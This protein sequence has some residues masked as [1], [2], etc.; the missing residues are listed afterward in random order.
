MPP[1]FEPKPD[2][3]AVGVAVGVYR[4]PSLVELQIRTIRHT[5]GPVP[6]LIS[7]DDPSIA[8]RVAEICGRFPDVFHW[9]NHER[10]GHTG[11][12]ISAFFKAALWG[13]ARGLRTVAKLSQRFLVTR[14]RWLQD[15]ARDLIESGL[16]IAT[17]RCTGT[18]RFD[19]RT[20]AVLLD[21]ATW[22]Q[23][24]VLSRIMPRRYWT[25]SPLGL[26]AET[27]IHRVL[28]DL[29][30]EFFHPWN[31]FDEE[32]AAARDGV[33]WHNANSVADYRQLAANHGV[34]L[35]AELHMDGWQRDRDRGTYLYG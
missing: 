13:K 22:S 30:G 4:W 14:P 20:E 2:D 5:C 24:E 17:Q 18:Q 8:A 23:S 21:V 9:P 34:E 25:D 6:I 12:D 7:N 11:G 32:R 27:V 33:L 28:K 35:D 29:A 31:L 26:S 10:I 1:V 16:S 19:L 3:P 15:G